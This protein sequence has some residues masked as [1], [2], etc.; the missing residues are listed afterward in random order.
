[1]ALKQL[2]MKSINL[3]FAFLFSTVVLA[4]QDRDELKDRV[5]SYRIGF[6]TDRLELTPE[7]SE[8]FWPV[9]RE[10]RKELDAVLGDQMDE[11][12]GLRKKRKADVALSD[13]EV[14]K[15]IQANFTRE[16]KVLKIKRSYHEKFKKVLPIQKVGK[17]YVAELE[18]K[19]ELIRKMRAE[20]KPEQ[21]GKK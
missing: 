18:F 10:F 6:L 21:R 4:Q 13:A 11:M 14:E 3:L 12:E 17:L 15:A 9:Y 20:R 19:K 7:E 1:M 8:K 5:E 16:E 2:I